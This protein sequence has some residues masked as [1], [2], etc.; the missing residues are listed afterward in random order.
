[1]KDSV[2]QFAA[3]LPEEPIGKGATWRFKRAA[4]AEGLDVATINRYELVEAGEGNP[5]FAVGGQVVAPRQKVER[6]GGSLELLAIDGKVSGRF[7]N[8]LRR[9]AP[10]GT[11]G[12]SMDMT[13]LSQKKRIKM[14]LEL[15]SSI[16]AR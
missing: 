5:T 2:E 13:V 10:A 15:D 1:M 12:V 4:K 11:F 16:T 14:H 8:D 7:A 6:L 9:F 3:P